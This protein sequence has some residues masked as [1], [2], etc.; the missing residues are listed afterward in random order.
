MS[1]E[2]RKR[3]WIELVEKHELAPEVR[4]LVFRQVEGEAM[5]YQAGQWIN[6]YLPQ[7]GEGLVRSYSL[8]EAPGSRS[9]FE[10][11]VSRVAEGQ[12]SP[13]L[14]ALEPGNR[15]EMDGPWG[16][17]TRRGCSNERPQV[18]IGTGT[19]LSPLR[20][21]LQEECLAAEGPPVLLLFGC[22]RECDIL[23]RRELEDLAQR[24]PRFRYV[25][26][27]S[28]SAE[29]WSGRRGYVQEHLPGL[30]AAYP[31][32]QAPQFYICGLSAMVEAVRHVLKEDLGVD[33]KSI[34]TE[35]YD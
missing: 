24:L 27:L 32:T 3:R 22:R 2:A 35:R 29:N 10:I 4:S 20:A 25:V 31:A 14:C 18:Y 23:W 17:F 12:A 7:E 8:T 13:R 26:T 15:I 28:Q 33:R 5:V 16:I 19:G 6:L 11:A 21:M 30:L 9:T 34:R 1:Q